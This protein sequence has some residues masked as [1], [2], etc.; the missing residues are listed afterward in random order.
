ML[1]FLIMNLKM[2]I[3]KLNKDIYHLQNE[4]III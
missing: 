2:H 4:H 3:L 1:V